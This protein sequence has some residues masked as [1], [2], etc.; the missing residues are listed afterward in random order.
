MFPFPIS[1]FLTLA[2][3]GSECNEAEVTSVSTQLA[4][5]SSHLSF[6]EINLQF[7]LSPNDVVT[8]GDTSLTEKTLN[9]L[10]E[11]DLS[12][13]GITRSTAQVFSQ[14]VNTCL[15]T[16]LQKIG[17]HILPNATNL[18]P[19]NDKNVLDRMMKKN[20]IRMYFVHSY[21]LE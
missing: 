9:K 3:F 2:C 17:V 20:Q 5:A 8:V 19:R 18:C 1:K 10:E 12:T 21:G 14:V 4:N 16:P 7:N 11:M 15:I 6:V 13:A